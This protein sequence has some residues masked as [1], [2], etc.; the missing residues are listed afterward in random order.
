MSIGKSVVAR[1]TD[2]ATLT[3]DVDPD[4][5]AVLH[6][7]EAV[8][9]AIHLGTQ[10]VSTAHHRHDPA[11]ELR[12][13][14]RTALAGRFP[15]AFLLTHRLSGLRLTRLLAR[16]AWIVGQRRSADE[17]AAKRSCQNKGLEQGHLRDSPKP[18]FLHFALNSL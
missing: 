9:V 6:D 8:G 2:H 13:R 17:A 12:Q 4:D 14:H 1:A 15:G 10:I 18:L 5:P 11:L 3:V 16:L 7:L